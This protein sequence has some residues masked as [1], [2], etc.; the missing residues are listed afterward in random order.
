MIFHQETSFASVPPQSEVTMLFLCLFF[1]HRLPFPHLSSNI[2]TGLH[3]IFFRLGRRLLSSISRSLL[4]C[5]RAGDQSNCQDGAVP[6]VQ[7]GSYMVNI[8]YDDRGGR[9]QEIWACSS[10]SCRVPLLE[11]RLLLRIHADSLLIFISSCADHA[12][13]S[14]AQ[15]DEGVSSAPCPKQEEGSKI[16]RVERGRLSRS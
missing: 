9:V 5:A 10:Y 8:G 1:S 4:C 3:N 13:T 14:P 15:W 2:F 11:G 7:G 12:A 6:V 16:T